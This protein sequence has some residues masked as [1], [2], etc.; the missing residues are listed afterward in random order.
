[1][2]LTASN[3]V[4]SCCLS[5]LCLLSVCLCPRIEETASLCNIYKVNRSESGQHSHEV[6]GLL[7]R[8]PLFV[9]KD[10]KCHAIGAHRN[11]MNATKICEKEVDTLKDGIDIFKGLLLHIVQETNTTGKPLTLQAEM[12]GQYEVD[13]HF[14]GYAIVSLNGKNIF[15]VDTS[16]GN[17][18]QLDH[19]FEKFIEM[20]KEDKVLAAFLK[21]TTEGDCRTWLD[22]LMLHWKE[23]LEPA[24]SFSTLMII[25]CVIAIVCLVF[26]IGVSCK[27]RHL[28]TKKIGLQSSPPPL[29][30]DSLTVPTSPQ[31]SVCG[32]MIQ[33]LCPRKLKSPVF[34]QIDLQSSAPPLLDDSL[35][36]PETCSVKK[37]DEFPTASQNS[38]L[39]TSD[40][41]DGIP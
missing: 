36:V 10:K 40:D 2:E 33:C 29:L 25:L 22:E 21:K 18:T 28:R 19:E 16:T 20:C 5:L 1:M 23:H 41:I 17:W 38:V 13:K 8:Q 11:S 6:Q 4:L 26:I 27:L 12:C 39:L 3:K 15:R 32:T 31:S 37:E 7:N 35:T 30:D 34:M 24:G 9:Y 14:T